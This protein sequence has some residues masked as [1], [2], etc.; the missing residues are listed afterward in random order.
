MILSLNS[1][2]AR[3]SRNAAVECFDYKNSNLKFEVKF[4]IKFKIIRNSCKKC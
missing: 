4:E 1:I 2:K 3:K